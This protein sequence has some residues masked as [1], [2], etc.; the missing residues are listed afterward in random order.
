MVRKKALTIR[1][2][3]YFIQPTKDSTKN[4]SPFFYIVFSK[5]TTSS[6]LQLLKLSLWEVWYRR[7]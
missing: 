4:L 6:V 7:S 2:S 1:P 3:F 5:W